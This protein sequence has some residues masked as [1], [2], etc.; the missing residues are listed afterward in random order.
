M[1]LS[2]LLC[3]T[4][5]SSKREEVITEMIAEAQLTQ[6]EPEYVVTW[7]KLPDDFEL[8][9]DPVENLDHIL[10]AAALR[11]ALEISGFILASMLVGWDFGICAKV[12]GKTVVKAPDWFYVPRVLPVQEGVTRRSY[13]PYAEGELPVIVMEF[14]S[15]AD[16]SEY[17]KEAK[18]PYG[19]WRFYE[20]ILQVPFYVI[21]DP[22]KG[23]L[24]VWRLVSGSYKLQQPDANGRYWIGEMSLFLGVWYGTKAE[25]TGSW[26]RWWDESGSM[27]LWGSEQLQQEQSRSAKLAAK[28][29]E[30]DIDPDSL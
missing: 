5:I 29:R 12:G 4:I 23:T 16:G 6:L 11:E 17:S 18:Y 25:R 24:E 7:E 3:A 30:L 20:K 21:F 8:P 27:L 19:K 2:L 14:L 28:L 22:K 26:L 9:D 13:T 10:L 15:D 1:P